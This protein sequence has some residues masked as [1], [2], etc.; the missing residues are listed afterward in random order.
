MISW[1]FVTGSRCKNIYGCST[2]CAK[3][4]RGYWNLRYKYPFSDFRIFVTFYQW[5]W[6]LMDTKFSGL[7]L[8]CPRLPNKPFEALWSRNVFIHFWK[9]AK[10]SD[11]GS[12]TM[13]KNVFIGSCKTCKSKWKLYRTKWFSSNDVE[14]N[15]IHKTSVTIKMNY[16]CINMSSFMIFCVLGLRFC[17]QVIND[18]WKVV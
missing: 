12:K 6:I 13:I 3:T 8:K 16:I 1:H 4:T 5:I 9:P 2:Y 11:F 7:T 15:R 17:Y 14:L 18:S 10:I